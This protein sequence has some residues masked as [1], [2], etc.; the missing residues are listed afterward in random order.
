MTSPRKFAYALTVLCCAP[1]MGI[2]TAHAQANSEPPKLTLTAID[3]PG[4]AITEVNGINS[5]GEMVG[6]YGQDF[7]GALSGFLYSNGTFTYF[8]YPGESVTSA[9][10]INDSGL[11]AG[12]ATQEAGQRSTIVGF[13]YDGSTFTTLQDGKDSATSPYGIN[14]AGTVVGDAGAIGVGRAFMMV[15]GKYSVVRLP[16]RCDLA[17][18]AGINNFGEIVGYTICGLDEYGY[19]VRG[20]KIQDIQFP[21]STQ[22]A[23][24]GINDRGVGVGWYGAGANTYAFAY[25]NGRYISFQYPGALYTFA[26]GINKSGQVAGSYTRSTIRPFT[27]SSLAP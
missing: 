4:A 9:Q 14:N 21:G 12:L 11:I 18:A 5:A 16:G 25:L 23:V 10:G 8:D 26:S 2:G 17:F 20:G 19:L 15:N 24:S 3:V 1:L 13:L 7:F 22:T 27:D 6:T